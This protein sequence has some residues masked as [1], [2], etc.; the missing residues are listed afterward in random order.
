M[1]MNRE[2]DISLGKV[3]LAGLI[4]ILVAPAGAAL[5]VGVF[6]LAGRLTG[7]KKKKEEKSWS[8]SEYNEAAVAYNTA[9]VRFNQAMEAEMEKVP[10]LRQIIEQLDQEVYDH[11]F[12]EIMRENF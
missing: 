7:R 8:V 6:A 3:A 5:A 1:M 11:V 10:R 9:V 4:G 12:D 2:S